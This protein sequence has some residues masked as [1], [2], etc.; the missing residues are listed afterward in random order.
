MVLYYSLEYLE[1]PYNV[2][3]ILYISEI[4]NIANV[5]ALEYI[6]MLM[7]LNCTFNFNIV[8]FYLNKVVNLPERLS[9]TCIKPFSLRLE[10]I[11][12]C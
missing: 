12:I 11:G 10:I 8:T 7:I 4:E 6:F 3:F 1:D 5:L 9:S 2:L